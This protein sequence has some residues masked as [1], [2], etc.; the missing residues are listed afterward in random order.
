MSKDEI[1]S[2][3][4]NEQ[5]RKGWLKRE[6]KELMEIFDERIGYADADDEDLALAE[7]IKKG[8]EEE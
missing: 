6:I 4:G 1:V 5:K 8:L 2:L 3:F 7:F